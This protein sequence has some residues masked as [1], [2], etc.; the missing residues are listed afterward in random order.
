V[1][2][3]HSGPRPD[4]ADGST[5][6][7]VQ[8]PVSPLKPLGANADLYTLALQIQHMLP[9]SILGAPAAVTAR[10]A[11]PDPAR[12]GQ[13]PP[14]EPH[15]ADLEADRATHFEAPTRTRL[16]LS[17]PDFGVVLAPGCSVSFG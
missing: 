3:W 13:H 17:H 6:E 15:I 7:P 10:S 8:Y 4:A 5:S 14:T 11:R 16:Y 1:T 9:A 2:P 12:S